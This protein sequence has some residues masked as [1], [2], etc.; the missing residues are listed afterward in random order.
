MERRRPQ[1]SICV[2]VPGGKTLKIAIPCLLAGTTL[3]VLFA[4]SGTTANAQQTYV[5]RY[6]VYA[7]FADIDSPMLGLNEHGFHLQAGMNM[8]TWLSVGADY[9]EGTADHDR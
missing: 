9:S 7:G 2:S 8:R 4:F 5:S 3:A 6:D 1:R